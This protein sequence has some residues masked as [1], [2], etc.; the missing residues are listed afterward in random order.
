MSA[1]VRELFAEVVTLPLFLGFS[2]SR[3]CREGLGDALWQLLAVWGS[4]QTTS[5]TRVGARASFWRSSGSFTSSLGDVENT[6]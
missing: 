5:R 6:S 2:W 3:E 1:R 4:S